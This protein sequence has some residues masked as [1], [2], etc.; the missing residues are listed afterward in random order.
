MKIIGVFIPL[1]LTSFKMNKYLFELKTMKVN[2]FLFCIFSMILVIH[3][4]MGVL[5]LGGG[6]MNTN[7]FISW[8]FYSLVFLF[9]GFSVTWS[10][11][12]FANWYMGEEVKN[13]TFMMFLFMFLMFMFILTS[14]IN[15]VFLLIGWEGVGIMSFLLINW[16]FGRGEAGLSGLQAMIYNRIGDFCFYIGIF[17]I[18]MSGMNVNIIGGY[19][20]SQNFNNFVFLLFLVGMMAKSSL[21]LFHPW[22]PNAMEGPTPV[23]ALLHSSTMVVAGVYLLCR[24]LGFFNFSSM[25]IVMLV[26][27]LT[28]LYGSICALGQFDM[29]KIIAHSTTS[30]LGLMVVTLGLGFPIISFF[31]LCMHAYVKSLIF[32]SS[33][34]FIHGIGGLQDYRKM[35]MGCISSKF[36]KLCMILCSLSL[37]GFPFMSGFYSKDSILEN[38]YGSFFNSFGSMLVIVGSVFTVAYSFRLVSLTF[39]V[40][41]KEGSFS[42]KLNGQEQFNTTFFFMSRLFI[43]GMLGGFFTFWSLFFILNEEHMG[44][45][46]KMIPLGILLLGLMIGS[47]FFFGMLMEFSPNTQL[48][49]YNPVIHRFQLLILFYG[50]NFIKIIEFWG[51]EMLWVNQLKKIP[52][53]SVLGKGFVSYKDYF[54]FGMF[55]LSVLFF[56]YFLLQ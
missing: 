16:W 11:L 23:S 41:S 56:L 14:S 13:K 49:Y 24:L 18:F 50:I 36:S 52:K 21:Y 8:D 4:H 26:G 22:L 25:G 53:F 33:G 48:L 47:K 10:I 35:M 7:F 45:W 9:I 6:W 2:S 15:L 39:L 12:D 44:G 54:I 40:D 43:W 30:Q 5:C 31:H 38:M 51:M 42:V 19:G 20:N 3:N 37:G 32:I 17:L 1:L 28:M 29:K 34:V 27:A 55:F 46:M